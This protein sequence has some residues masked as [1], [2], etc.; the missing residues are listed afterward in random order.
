MATIEA[1]LCSISF[2][3]LSVGEVAKL[4]ADAGLA[5]IE[6]GGDV[7]VPPGNPEAATAAKR[8]TEEAGLRVG[9]YGSYHWCGR[10]DDPTATVAAAEALGADMIRVWMGPG[11][12]GMPEGDW[13]TTSPADATDLWQAAI[14]ELDALARRAADAGLRVGMEYHPNTLTADPAGVLRLLDGLSPDARRVASTYWQPNQYLPDDAAG[15]DTLR[16]VLPHVSNLHVFH[17]T[18]DVEGQVDRHPLAEGIHRWHKW[19]DLL[20]ADVN[21]LALLEFVR[22]DDPANLSPDATALLASL[23]R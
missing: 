8:A 11:W 21:R 10:G 15:T 20:P 2:R 3:K 1:G 12:G 23:R 9:S 18:T 16:T 5:M 22:H 14:A 4:A 13:R 17:W 7:H 19:L 6:W